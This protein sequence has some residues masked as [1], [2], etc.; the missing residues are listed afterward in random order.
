MN[1]YDVC[2]LMQLS[3]KQFYFRIID[4]NDI[5]KVHKSA[6]L[7]DLFHSKVVYWYPRWDASIP[8]PK[9]LVIWEPNW[10]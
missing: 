2:S 10:V 1:F 9:Q 4:R 3:W 6:L 8:G 7:M 5:G